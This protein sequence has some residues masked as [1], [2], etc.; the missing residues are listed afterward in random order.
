MAAPGFVHILGQ[1]GAV[2]DPLRD[3]YDQAFVLLGLVSVYGLG[4]NAQ[5]RAE[6]NSPTVPRE[7]SIQSVK[8]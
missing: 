7:Y 3:T 1:D 2:L 4:Q 6:I 8:M 5:V